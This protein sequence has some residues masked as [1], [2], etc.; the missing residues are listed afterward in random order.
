MTTKRSGFGP[1]LFD[2]WRYLGRGEP[3]QDCS[4]R[5]GESRLRLEP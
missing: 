1:F 4:A 2:E 3:G 5:L